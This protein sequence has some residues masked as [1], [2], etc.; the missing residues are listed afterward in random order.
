MHL[1]IV[2]LNSALLFSSRF[3]ILVIQTGSALEID[4]VSLVEFLENLRSF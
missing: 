1:F 4:I 3:Y 2:S